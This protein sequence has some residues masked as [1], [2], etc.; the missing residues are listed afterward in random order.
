MTVNGKVWGK[1]IEGQDFYTAFL[2]VFLGSQD[3]DGRL[4]TR[5]LGQAG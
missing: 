2:K 5:L 3:S 1:P 4:R